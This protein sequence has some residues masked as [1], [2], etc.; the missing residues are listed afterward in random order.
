MAVPFGPLTWYETLERV[1]ANAEALER[2]F[3]PTHLRTLT[4]S[5]SNELSVTHYKYFMKKLRDTF[6]FRQPE[7]RLSPFWI[8]ALAYQ[9]TVEWRNQNLG[10]GE[11]SHNPLD[12]RFYVPILRLLFHFEETPGTVRA[13]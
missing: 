8:R 7:V 9:Y 4:L 12:V 3:R 5:S 1:L 11:Q 13:M 10:D 6:V 2:E